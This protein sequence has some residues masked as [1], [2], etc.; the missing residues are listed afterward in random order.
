MAVASAAGSRPYVSIV[1]TG[2]NDG[3]GGDFVGRFLATLRFNSRELCARGIPHEFVLVEWAPIPGAALL[4]DLV[5]AQCPPSVTQAL[6]TIVVD[7]AYHEAVTLNPRLKYQEYIAK[8]VGIRRVR[9]QYVITSNCDIFLGRRILERL[10]SRDLRPSTLY[11][12]PRWDLKDRDDLSATDWPYLEDP[13]SLS[14]R[15]RVIKPPYFSGGAGDFIL[16]DRDTFHRLGG[17]NE[18]YRVVRIA[19]D[20]N[21]VVNAAACGV[22]IA[23]VGGP[24]YHL[25]HA[26]SYR[27]SRTAFVGREAEAPYGDERWAVDRVVYRNRAGWGFAAAPEREL[28]PRRVYLDFAQEAVPP[29]V[30]LAALIPLWQQRERAA[31]SGGIMTLPEARPAAVAPDSR[32]PTEGEVQQYAQAVRDLRAALSDARERIDRATTVFADVRTFARRRRRKAGEFA[33]KRGKS[34]KNA[35]SG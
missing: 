20:G 8:N 14:G 16:L 23:D 1:L 4:A 7:P 9:G 13:S 21:F 2:R 22:A 11:R 12:A 31:T 30:D 3:Y 18:V 34:L 24:A 32:P 27:S 10:E 25:D 29:F 26:G 33:E 28:G 17:F 6:Q 35:S 19:I 15:A 5:E